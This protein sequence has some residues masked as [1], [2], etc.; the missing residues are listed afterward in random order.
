[1]VNKRIY[2]LIM[3]MHSSAIA[4]WG[5]LASRDWCAACLSFQRLLTRCTSER[6]FTL[7]KQLHS[8]AVMHGD[9]EPRNVVRTASQ[10]FLLIDFSESTF[11]FC[12]DGDQFDVCLTYSKLLHNLT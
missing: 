5:A 8:V 11:H 7:V 12:P 6:I 10:G 9:I 1:L 2:A 3:D 4:K